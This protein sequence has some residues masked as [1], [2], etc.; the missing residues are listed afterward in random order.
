MDWSSPLGNRWTLD[1]DIDVIAPS[2]MEALID[3]VSATLQARHWQAAEGAVP[4]SQGIGG[5]VDTTVAK[6]LYQSAKRA[7][8]HE[9]A[10]AIRAVA[11]GAIWPRLTK[12]EREYAAEPYCTRC[13]AKVPEDLRHWGYQCQAN[14][15]V[16]EMSE[17][18]EIIL[19]AAAGWDSAPLLFGRGLV[20][21]DMLPEV[22]VNFQPQV[23]EEGATYGLWDP[24]P[25]DQHWVVVFGDASMDARLPKPLR[26][27]GCA[28]V[29]CPWMRSQVLAKR[30]EVLQGPRQ[31]VGRG[32]IVRVSH[33]SSQHA[34]Q[35]YVHVRQ[36][37]RV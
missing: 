18:N 34:G 4:F 36:V 26:R 3:E 31:E 10:G 35:Y 23:L 24:Q 21:R 9:Y 19:E 11:T 25:H 8:R 33:G 32:G 37:E 20:P 16:K 2:D 14:H 12:F 15:E 6:R 28:I 27:V 30:A 29:Q 17:H 1:P 22:S 13:A 7:G 5:G